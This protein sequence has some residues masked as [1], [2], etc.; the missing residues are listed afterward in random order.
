MQRDDAP[1]DPQENLFV[2]SRNRFVPVYNPGSDGAREL[3]L[4]C[5]PHEITF[6]E[7]AL[8]PWAETLIQQ[9]TFLAGSAT[10]WSSEPLSWPRVQE[11]LGNLIEAGVLARSPPKETPQVVPSAAHLEFLA[12]EDARKAPPTARF[13]NPDAPSMLRDIAGRTLELGYLEAVVPVHRVAHIALDREGRQVG[14]VNAFPEQLRLKV[15]TEWRTCAYAGTRHGDDMPMNLTALKTM[16]SH[17]QPAL[18]TALSV[19]D[20][21]LERY[22]QLPGGGLKLGDLHLLSCAVLALPAVLLMRGK[23][24][25]SNGD[26]DPVLSTLFRA[27]DGVRMVAAQMLDLPG[28]AV[29]HETPVVP[30]DVTDAAERLGQY[31]SERGVCAGP[32]AMI[33][34][35]LATLISGATVPDAVRPSPWEQEIAR[36]IDY[37]LHGQLV[38]AAVSILWVRMGETYGR[39]RDALPASRPRGR[40]GKLRSAVERDWELLVPSHRDAGRRAFSQRMYRRMFEEAQRGIRGRGS[41]VDLSELLDTSQVLRGGADGALREVFVAAEEA[42]TAETN[43][44]LLQEIAGHV[45]EYLRIERATLALVTSL[46]RDID[47]LLERP[48]PAGPLQASQ[49]AI[50]HLLRKGTASAQPYLIDTVQETLGISIDGDPGSTIVRHGGHIL[51][52]H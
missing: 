43:G 52:L 19:R 8:F 4:Y 17:W 39:I 47:Q 26:L 3:S 21:F 7:A 9:D 48:H 50:Y 14:E 31:R 25:V 28:S 32:P 6:D 44:P 24:P 5:G 13:W 2:V 15:R 1:V 51:H 34:E 30:R 29:A 22:P 38:H 37:A 27:V 20:A 12:R 36:A 41:I 18:A 49:L 46:E 10:T 45:L 35:L 23:K 16:V 40:L 33:A 11:L 42:F